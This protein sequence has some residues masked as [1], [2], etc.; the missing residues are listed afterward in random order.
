MFALETVLREKLQVVIQTGREVWFRVGVRG[1]DPIQTRESREGKKISAAT[2]Q[3]RA[4][5]Q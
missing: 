5:T 4:D 1:P 3:R 2:S